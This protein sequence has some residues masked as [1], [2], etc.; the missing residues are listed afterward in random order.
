MLAGRRG[1]QTC[2]RTAG[3]EA[4]RAAGERDVQAADLG[5]VFD[6]GG[7]RPAGRRFGNSSATAQ[8]PTAP[9][10]PGWL[11]HRLSACGKLVAE[12]MQV[13]AMERRCVAHPTSALPRASI[14]GE[15]RAVGSDQG[16]AA[17]DEGGQGGLCSRQ[18][19]VAVGHYRLVEAREIG[20]AS[21][22]T[23]RWRWRPAGSPAWR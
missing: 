23:G 18:R 11:G 17:A 19:Q 16:L 9:W 6:G 3:H 5:D 13:C 7:C 15:R 12:I 1:R 4:G 22:T 2:P 8:V 14:V 10:W 20:G 21:G